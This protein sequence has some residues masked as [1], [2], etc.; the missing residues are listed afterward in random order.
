MILKRPKIF[1]L[2][3]AL[4]LAFLQILPAY[5]ESVPG[6]VK[7]AVFE[8]QQPKHFSRLTGSLTSRLRDLLR[9]N[10]SYE[11]APFDHRVGSLQSTLERARTLYYRQVD[12]EASQ[13]ILEERLSD[14]NSFLP[15]DLAFLVPSCLFLGN[16]YFASGN[17]EKARQAFEKAL[18]YDPESKLSEQEYSPTVRDFFGEVKQEVLAKGVPPKKTGILP[19]PLAKEG[20]SGGIILSKKEKPD[21]KIL[22]SLLKD[23]ST[24]GLK[25][26]RVALVTV[27]EAKGDL[28]EATLYLADAVR[29]RWIGSRS[30]TFSEGSGGIDF[31]AKLLMGHVTALHQGEGN[32]DLPQ[33]LSHQE[34]EV[35]PK[36][37]F[38]RKPIVWII[39]GLILAGAG[40]G[41]GLMV[42]S[43]SGNSNSVGIASPTGP[44]LQIP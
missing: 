13:K 36:K 20:I 30:V 23:V 40:A 32:N 17:K 29:G 43:G 33:N 7:I 42:A 38:W 9:Q 4:N 14:E 44:T 39:G 3:L 41:I 26:D 18:G 16:V 35:G 11:L 12:L 6:T 8:L 5:A 28:R 1:S 2:L 27:H 31:G 10:N 24:E 34:K 21:Q 37:S 15:E 19:V 22:E 25:L